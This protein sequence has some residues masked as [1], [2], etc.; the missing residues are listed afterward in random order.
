[1]SR[2]TGDD[3]VQIGS[4]NVRLEAILSIR[5]PDFLGSLHASFDEGVAHPVVE[6]PIAFVL[7]AVGLGC[8]LGRGQGRGPAGPRLAI[9]DDILVDC[10]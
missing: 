6:L 2:K 1:M 9:D 7:I 3:G 8:L 4:R 5:K 10:L